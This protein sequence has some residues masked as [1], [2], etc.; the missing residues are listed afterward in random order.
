[1]GLSTG[2]G[3]GSQH[4]LNEVVAARLGRSLIVARPRGAKLLKSQLKGANLIFGID[5]N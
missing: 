5:K 1:M 3:R 2:H 4:H